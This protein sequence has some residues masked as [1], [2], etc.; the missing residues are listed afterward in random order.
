MSYG[1]WSDVAPN[2][3][4]FGPANPPPESAAAGQTERVIKDVVSVRKYFL[5]YDAA[6]RERYWDVTPAVL[7]QLADNFHAMK[8]H[9]Q[10]PNLV[11][12]H[13]DVKTL[14]V[15][16]DDLMS[17]IDDVKVAGDTLWMSSYVT[18][19]EKAYLQKPAR[20]VSIGSEPNYMDAQKI[21]YPGDSL[22]HVAVT[23]R[24]A[25]NGQGPFIALA[26]GASQGGGS[27]NPDLVKRINTMWGLLGLGPMAEVADET[28]LFMLMDDRLKGLGAGKSPDKPAEDAPADPLPDASE[29]PLGMSAEPAVMQAYTRIAAENKVLQ[30]RVKD[31]EDEKA[32]SIR[33]NFMLQCDQ[34]MR[35]PV[36]GRIAS[37]ADVDQA[38]ALAE[39][40]KSYD[41]GIVA[42]IPRTL[43]AGGGLAR[44]LA[45]PNPPNVS[46]DDPA[47]KKKEI[48][49]RVAK[50]RGISVE[51]A[52][53]LVP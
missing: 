13:G 4:D 28:Q 44:T 18:P 3:P 16:P 23:D 52:L 6:G 9:G 33:D 35:V 32:K 38:K 26:D 51:A 7:R 15:H 21:S 45:D 10:R 41:L 14:M 2:P 1:N 37:K 20:K 43:N 50:A 24:A 11:K 53:A 8:A 39:R 29:D 36:N 22:I 47:A 25:S 49:A 19:E 31:A 12:T 30:Q 17:P 5:G 48:A 46:V 27:M 42:L 40:L 34:S